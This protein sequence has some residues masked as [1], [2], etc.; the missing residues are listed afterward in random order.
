MRV[1]FDTRWIGSHGIGRFAAE[2]WNRMKGQVVAMPGTR[3]PP[4]HPL[5][6]IWASFIINISEVHVYFT[7]GYNAPL[8][9]RI[10]IVLT[11]HDLIHLQVPEE[12]SIPKRL[13]YNFYLRR[14]VQTCASV[15]T[16]SEYSKKQIIRWSGLEERKV[17][18]APNGASKE[19]RPTGERFS[20]GYP[21]ILH[22]GNHKP[23][24]NLRGLIKGF[25][26]ACEGD[27][28]HLLLTGNEEPDLV[29]LAQ[30]CGVRHKVHFIGHIAEA[31][32]PSYYRGALAVAIVSFIEG[33]G[34][35]ALEAMACGTP[36]VASNAASLP[37]VVGEAA[38]YI[39]P[40]SEES[41]SKGISQVVRGNSLR[42]ML[43]NMGIARAKLFSWEETAS[44]VRQ[45]LSCAAEAAADRQ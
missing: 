36:V 43:R 24:K 45:V 29:Q 14:A 19:F 37:E 40:Y 17:F 10:P 4:Y 35:P 32:L 34:L 39:D 5:D 12:G 27:E 28:T 2:I 25:A 15:I 3:F 42:E 33:F 8:Y 30:D 7:P 23:H 21:Y 16:V 20:P 31:D 44:K 38:V 13:Y 18:I 1:L 22:V 41:I 6:I 26:A 9:S 11:I